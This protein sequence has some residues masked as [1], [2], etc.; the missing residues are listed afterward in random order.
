MLC[1]RGIRYFDPAAPCDSLR[2]DQDSEPKFNCTRANA[3]V[4]EATNQLAPAARL[5]SDQAY[6]LESALDQVPSI[7]DD[8]ADNP[9]QYDRHVALITKLSSP[10]LLPD[11]FDNFNAHFPLPNNLWVE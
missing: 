3:S 11:A 4:P 5:D 1:G 6:A 9:Y 10:D 7:A 8:L 2:D